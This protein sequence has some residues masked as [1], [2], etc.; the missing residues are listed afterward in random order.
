MPYGDHTVLPATRQKWESRLYPQPKQVL[1]LATPEGCKAELT[2]FRELGIEPATCQSQVQRPTASPPHSTVYQNVTNS[3][4]Y[5][6]H[7]YEPILKNCWLL[8]VEQVSNSKCAL[9]FQLAKL[10]LLH[11]L[12]KLENTKIASFFTQNA[13]LRVHAMRHFTQSLLDFFSVDDSHHG[14]KTV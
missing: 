4:C 3:C 2:M 1:D 12:A 10:M 6:V 11:Y 13:L 8:V 5:D 7:E 14:S 9:F